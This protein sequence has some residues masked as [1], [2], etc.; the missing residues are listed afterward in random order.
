ME[1]LEFL[2]EKYL[3]GYHLV[4]V[5]RKDKTTYLC[6][7]DTEVKSSGN[8]RGYDLFSLPEGF[9]WPCSFNVIY[10]IKDLI[11]E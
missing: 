1:E 2:K 7:K 11:K 8:I 6:S 4:V 10:K 3:L 9:E 5:T